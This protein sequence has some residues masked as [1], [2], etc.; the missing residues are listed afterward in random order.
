MVSKIS[1]KSILMGL[2]VLLPI[3]VCVYLYVSKEKTAYINMKEV[4]NNFEYK[5]E[6]EK[7]YNKAFLAKK[8]LLDS[9][10]LD[11]EFLMAHKPGP[12]ENVAELEEKIGILQKQYAFKQN[13]YEEENN[14][15]VDKYNEEIWGQLNQYIGNYGKEKGY[16]YI[17]GTNGEGNL[18][19]AKENKDITKT[20]LE[21]VNAKYQG[22]ETK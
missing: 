19:Y 14:V 22:N 1:G 7:K 16:D 5:K 12:K 17:F 13:Q 15:A 11:L 10:R 8:S 9:L 6:A 18:M 4:F 2:A 3:A 21:Y 20:V